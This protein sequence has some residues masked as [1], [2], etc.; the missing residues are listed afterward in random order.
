MRSFRRTWAVGV[1]LAAVASGTA[2]HAEAL[3]YALELPD[4]E[5]I[6]YTLELQ[7]VH[8]GTLVVEANWPGHRVLSLKLEPQGATWSQVVRRSGPPPQRIETQAAGGGGFPQNW[9]LQVYALAAAGGGSGSLRIVLPGPP[10][11]PRPVA[12]PAPPTP[13]PEVEPW[14]APHPPAAGTPHDWRAFFAATESYRGMIATDGA[15]SGGDVCQWQSELMRYLASAR[16]ALLA[17]GAF[18]DGRTRT[19]LSQIAAAIRVVEE[20]NGSSDPLLRGPRPDDPLAA[21]RWVQLRSVR[22]REIEAQLDGVLSLIRQSFAPQ[23]AD[24]SWPIRLVSC[25][26]ACER[27][28]DERAQIGEARATNR[29]LALAQLPRMIAAARALEELAA[30]ES[31][32]SAAR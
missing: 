10:E 5:S 13:A 32:S 21:D 3:L 4:G 6:S 22:I 16:D 25:A 31:P 29:D 17:G 20:M 8:P 18:P 26:T 11:P 14:L 30:L 28:I 2:A 1:L 24:E 23:L 12:A 27:F 7:V 15:H 19:I 9:T